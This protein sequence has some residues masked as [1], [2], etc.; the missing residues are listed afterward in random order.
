MRI[1]IS[2]LIIISGFT[3]LFLGCKPRDKSQETRENNEISSLLEKRY[4]NL[5]DYSVDSLAFPRSFDLVSGEI[6]K[7]PSKDWTSGFFPGNLWQ[8]YLLTGD[9]DFKEKARQWN[10]F[11]EKEKF[12]DGT[13]DMGFKVYGSLGKA[14]QVEE[15]NHY[16]DVILESAKTLSTRFNKTVGC[17][18]SWDFNRDVWEFPVIID[19]MMNL[20]LL[21]EATQMSGDSTYFNIAV[22][23]ANTS[24]ENHFRDDHSSYH[25]VV[26]DTVTGAVKNKLT[27][28]GFNDESSW[29]RGQA[30]AVYGYTMSYRYTKRKEYLNQAESSAN[31]F[32]DN[33]HLPQDGIP[34]WDFD[35]PQIPKS[36]RDVSAATIMSSALIELFEIT[37]KEKY[38]KYSDKVIKSLM[39]EEYIISE[40][41]EAPFILDHST[42]NWPKNDEID[43]PIVYADYYFLET[44]LRRRALK[45]KPNK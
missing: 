17:I 14:L 27:H 13:H 28:Q 23:H 20:E 37:G 22:S 18:R 5:K 43:G 24:L 44:L 34:Y 25:V 1:G 2:L 40:D 11:I 3:S 10:A 12:N 30:W 26:Y 38:L 35:D 42:G 4:Q 36:P 7:V 29:A 9:K 31:Y 19:N 6:K 16:K 45:S 32:L 15:N 8:L 33:N 39:S 41:I 21:F